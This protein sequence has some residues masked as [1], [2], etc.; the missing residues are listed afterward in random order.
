[1]GRDWNRVEMPF[2]SE[3]T[4]SR[5]HRFMWKLFRVAFYFGSNGSSYGCRLTR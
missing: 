3:L 4:P 2:Q 1:V 5:R